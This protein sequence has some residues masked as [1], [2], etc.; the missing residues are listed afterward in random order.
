M[1]LC[2]IEALA[3]PVACSSMA[4]SVH[5]AVLA[6]VQPPL[7]RPARHSCTP[8]GTAAYQSKPFVACICMPHHYGSEDHVLAPAF[9][10]SAA[11]QLC[12]KSQRSH[13]SLHRQQS[14]SRVQ[15]SPQ[16]RPPAGPRSTAAV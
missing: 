14:L 10:P 7:K 1:M 4:L 2:S 3:M 6:W 8:A 11:T 13:S 5:S 12:G 16:R 15:V 9:A